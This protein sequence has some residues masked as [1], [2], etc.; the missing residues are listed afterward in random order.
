MREADT[1]CY[2]I[3]MRMVI[4]GWVSGV[5]GKQIPTFKAA[6]IEGVARV[7]GDTNTGLTGSQ[8]SQRLSEVG[9]RDVDPVNTKWK[10]L[11]NALVTHQNRYQTGKC[12]V[13]FIRAAMDPVLFVDDRSRFSY[14]QDRLNLVLV[15]AGLRV[16]DKGQV[17]RFKA[18]AA[19]TLDEA[20][21]LI[22]RIR[23]ELRRPNTHPEVERY[24][25]EELLAKNNFHAVL[26]AAKSVP[27]RLR[28]MTGVDGDGAEVV[29]T[30]LL[31][32]DRPL[33][34]IN[35]GITKSDRSEQAGLA[36][37]AL[38]LVGLYRNPTAHDPK[39]RRTVSDDELLE[40]LTTMSMVHRRLDQATVST[41]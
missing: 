9:I 14:L 12:V 10:R 6:F 37:V 29:R 20:A 34:A 25:T 11:Y 36:N 1:A 31:P 39:I 7:L 16:N 23:T 27:D 15:H 3:I 30:T 5:A 18:G 17:A 28:A 33:V 40:A 35:A 13:G 21:V 26:E 8:I 41:P 38:G 2:S 32:A 24:C 22:G 19:A 4:P